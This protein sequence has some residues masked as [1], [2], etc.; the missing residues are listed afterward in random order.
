LEKFVCEFPVITVGVVR[1]FF[2]PHLMYTNDPKFKK[3]TLG[4][5]ACH[6]HRIADQY[7]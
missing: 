6:A 1:A 2:A 7:S 5:Y 4:P 3:Y